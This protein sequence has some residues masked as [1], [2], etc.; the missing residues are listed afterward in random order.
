M[1]D[2]LKFLKTFLRVLDDSVTELEDIAKGLVSLVREV[3]HLEQ[4][5]P[6]TRAIHRDTQETKYLLEEKQQVVRYR[7]LK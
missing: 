5:H 1:T 3:A 6:P 2:H 4:G 7:E